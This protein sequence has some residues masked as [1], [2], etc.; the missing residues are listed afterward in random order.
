MTDT[1]VRLSWALPLVLLL[2]VVA[3]LLLRRFLPALAPATPA[4]GQLVLRESLRVSERTQLH[5]VVAQGR[6]VLLV[7][8]QEGS[9]TAVLL[10][11]PA[12]PPAGRLFA[13]GL[14]RP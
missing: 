2:G 8:P 14:R 12:R 6:P 10:D 1:L 7:E 5:L 3:L 13:A 11:D 9:P 4:A